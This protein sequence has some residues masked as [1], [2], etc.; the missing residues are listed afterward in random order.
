[1]YVCMYV[2][3]CV[4]VYVFMYVRMRVFVCVCMYVFMYV[5][6]RVRMY[7]CMYVCKCYVFLGTK[8]VLHMYDVHK[9]VYIYVNMYVVYICPCSG[10]LSP[11]H[12]ASSGCG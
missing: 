6:M 11:R 4:C 10:S 7:V 5:R 9:Y 3:V 8:Y 2:C 12:G 1:M